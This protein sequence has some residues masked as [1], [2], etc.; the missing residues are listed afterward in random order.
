MLTIAG[1]HFTVVELTLSI[2]AVDLHQHIFLWQHWDYRMQ[3]LEHWQVIILAGQGQ[4]VVVVPSGMV[5][6]FLLAIVVE[7]W[8]L[9]NLA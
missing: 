8:L 5:H 7:L 4:L 9:N 1:H 6:L 2:V 3:E